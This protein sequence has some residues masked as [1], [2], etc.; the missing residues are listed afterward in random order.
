MWRDSDA[1]S[2]TVAPAATAPAIHDRRRPGRPPTVSPHLI[3]LLRAPA[4]H[5]DPRDVDLLAPA[6]GI[7]VAVLLSLP[8]WAVCGIVLWV[9]G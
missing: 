4:E 1:E 8:F 2:P 7:G 6:R 5:E 3:P 9:F